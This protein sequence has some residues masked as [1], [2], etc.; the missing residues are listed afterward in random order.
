MLHRGS[1]WRASLPGI[2]YYITLRGN[3]HGE[4]FY[5]QEDR[6]DFLR[7]LQS[8]AAPF[9]AAQAI[10]ARSGIVILPIKRICPPD[11]PTSPVAASNWL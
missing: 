9:L 7:L 2:P 6:R 11:L 1:D 3:R 10:T 8:A 5:S 4:I